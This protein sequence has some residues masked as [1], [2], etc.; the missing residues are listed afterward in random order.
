MDSQSLF[1]VDHTVIKFH[2]G[3]FGIF[4]PLQN[5]NRAELTMD[6]ARMFSTEHIV[7]TQ[8]A[9]YLFFGRIP[10]KVPQYNPCPACVLILRTVIKPPYKALPMD[11][12]HLMKHS[13]QLLLSLFPVEELE[14]FLCLLKCVKPNNPALYEP[15]GLIEV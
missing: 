15:R 14:R 4:N 1:S 6:Y 2:S 11:T 3:S 10:L 5:N 9:L 8:F 12:F 7:L 13:A